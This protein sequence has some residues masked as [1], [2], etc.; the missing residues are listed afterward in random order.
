MVDAGPGL[1]H[2]AQRGRL[3]ERCQRR[4]VVVDAEIGER[5]RQ[6][7][8]AILHVDPIERAEQALANRMDVVARAGFAPLIDDSAVGDHHHRDRL[9]RFGVIPRVAE[10]GARPTGGF[11]RGMT[12]PLLS[13]KRRLHERRAPARG[14]AQDEDQSHHRCRERS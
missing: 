3:L 8:L 7:D 6:V 14:G 1:D 10:P 4:C 2:I 12:L 9:D 11:R 5:F 13:R